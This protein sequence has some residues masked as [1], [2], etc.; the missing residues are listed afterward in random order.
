MN[1]FAVENDRDLVANDRGLHRLPFLTGLGGEHIRGLDAIDGS[2]AVQVGFAAFEI[3]EDLKF[4][5]ASQILYGSD[6]PFAV[7]MMKKT[8]DGLAAY[9]FAPAA[10]AAIERD[11]AARLFPRLAA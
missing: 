2:I 8:I 5:P 4:V 7:G 6:Y 10:R 9:D 1:F 11:N 3:A